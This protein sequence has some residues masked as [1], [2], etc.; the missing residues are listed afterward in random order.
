MAMGTASGAKAV[1]TAI[2]IIDVGIVCR[3]CSSHSI[4]DLAEI[5]DFS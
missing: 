4:P 2:I 5:I 1:S 3:S